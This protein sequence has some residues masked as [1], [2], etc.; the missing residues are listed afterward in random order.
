MPTQPVAMTPIRAEKI[1]PNP[2]QPR[3]IFDPQAI[4]DLKESM[5]K[6]GL[7][8]PIAV[9]KS[10]EDDYTIIAGER[11]YRAALELK[12]DSIDCRIWPAETT[13]QEVEMLA[14]IENTQ[15]QDLNPIERAKGYQ[16]LAE[17][18]KMSH[19]EIAQAMG[20]SNNSVVS[21][22]IALL[23]MPQEIQDLLPRGSISE[24]HCRALRQITD[25]NK[26]IELAKRI[27]QEGWSVRDTEKRVEALNTPAAEKPGK[28]A[29]DPVYEWG[30]QSFQFFRKGKR[31]SILT[32][33]L[34]DMDGLDLYMQNLRCALV[35][36]LAAQSKSKVG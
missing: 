29:A 20:M 34:T 5:D 19:D 32:E 8:C 28:V 14:L 24:G 10:G 30:G 26:Q 25:K 17:E 1:H 35:D 12:W 31:F 33:P 11:R 4:E 21:R 2:N 9:F 36:Y 13:P 16:R 6:R 23:E 15:R 22:H 3:K 7:I 18:F 27:D